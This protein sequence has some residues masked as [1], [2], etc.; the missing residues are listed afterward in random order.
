MTVSNI[1][2]ASVLSDP[3]GKTASTIMQEVLSS[4]SIDDKKI[5]SLIHGRCKNKDKILDSL[6][7]SNISS[8]QHFKMNTSF[9]HMQEFN[10]SDYDSF[11]NPKPY[12]SKSL[13]VDSALAFLQ[14]QG[15]DT[16]STQ[17]FS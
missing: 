12:S 3:F 13:D 8:D 17:L 5:L 10:P 15:Y 1:G 7:D 6:K 14:Q 9:L 4:N 11:K 16:S 2:L